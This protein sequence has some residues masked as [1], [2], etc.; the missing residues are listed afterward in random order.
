MPIYEYEVILDDGEPGMRFEVTQGLN[1]PPLTKH[2]M[3]GQPVRRVISK[4]VL[5]GQHSDH[6]YQ[7]TLQDEKKLGEMGFTKYVRQGKG[8]YE[9]RTG[10]GPDIISAD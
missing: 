10:K 3:T 4:P 1:D 8:V 9:K 2:P 6:A 5:P 7:Q